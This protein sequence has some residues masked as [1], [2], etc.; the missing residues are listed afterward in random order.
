MTA[1]HKT[2]ELRT[3]ADI[4]NMVPVDRIGV[5]MDELRLLLVTTANLRDMI[6]FGSP[7]Q[8][9]GNFKVDD[10]FIWTDDGKGKLSTEVSFGDG[11]GLTM[12]IQRDKGKL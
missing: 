8:P 12:E 7:V 5:C 11:S 10:V 9:K 1:T 4:F 2:Y 6:D 3:I